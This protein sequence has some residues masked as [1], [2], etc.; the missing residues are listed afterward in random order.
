MT[1][2]WHTCNILSCIRSPDF[3]AGLPSCTSVTY[4]P[5]KYAQV[6]SCTRITAPQQQLDLTEGIQR[7]PLDCENE[8]TWGFSL[9]AYWRIPLQH[10]ASLITVTTTDIHVT[11][12]AG[13]RGIWQNMPQG[14]I[15]K[16]T[17]ITL[18]TVTCWTSN[19]FYHTQ[20]M[21]P[22]HF[23]QYTSLALTFM[24]YIICS[25]HT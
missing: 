15:Y 8:E 13:W 6:F 16:T 10:T 12:V 24:I 2:Q 9:S 18:I 25:I 4:M 17:T 3:A 7:S 21:L 14:N 22:P 5:C 19:I 20:W 23:P 11:R 1:E